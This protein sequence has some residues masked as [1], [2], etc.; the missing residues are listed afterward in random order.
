MTAISAAERSFHRRHALHRGRV[1]RLQRQGAP[2]PPGIHQ[3]QLAG[4]RRG[5]DPAQRAAG[6]CTAGRPAAAA[7]CKLSQAGTRIHR[8]RLGRHRHRRW[9]G[10]SHPAA[11]GAGAVRAVQ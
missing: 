1:A 3:R 4:A 9:P 5:A 11:D 6:R 10:L 2:R 7:R 8:D